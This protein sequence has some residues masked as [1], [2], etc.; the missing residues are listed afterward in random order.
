MASDPSDAWVRS[1]YIRDLA[2]GQA[3]LPKAVALSDAWE[4]E[5]PDT[6]QVHAVRAMVALR[7]W[8]WG[9][10]RDRAAAEQAV[11][12]YKA[13]I[14]VLPPADKE[15]RAAAEDKIV[16]IE[17]RWRACA[18]CALTAAP[19]RNAEGIRKAEVPNNSS[20]KLK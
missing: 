17:P 7:Q 15:A 6:P 4:R 12:E 11:K 9:H 20:I 16:V 2:Q 13:V 18:C 10:K 19:G 3:T 14:R 1:H 5:A 8:T